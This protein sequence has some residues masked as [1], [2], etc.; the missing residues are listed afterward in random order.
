[1]G[2]YNDSLA[3]ALHSKLSRNVSGRDGRDSRKTNLVI[4]HTYPIMSMEERVLS[5]LGCKYVSDVLVDAPYVLS[6]NILSSL[7]I[8]CVAI[9]STC[10]LCRKVASSSSGDRGSESESV[11]GSGSGSGSGSESE[12]GSNRVLMCIQCN[13][14]I[15][16]EGESGEEY[17]HLTKDAMQSLREKGN[18]KVLHSNFSITG[19][20]S[21]KTIR[22][23]I[24]MTS[25]IASLI[26]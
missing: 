15:G 3:S 2:I 6:S 4:D 16:G 18:V 20:K 12:S 9:E 13:A 11:G 14:L 25:K 7:N 19:K 1:M 8:T 23:N 24:K 17:T 26:E 5:I 21:I 10:Q 22:I